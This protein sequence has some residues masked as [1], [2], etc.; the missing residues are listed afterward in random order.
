MTL[1]PI[2]ESER[3]RY[4]PL[5]PTD[6]DLARALFLDADVARYVGG[7]MQPGAITV[8]SM[9]LWT[10]RSMSG[11]IG[12]WVIIDKMVGEKLGT[13]ILLPM[14]V[15]GHDTDWDCIVGDGTPPMDIETGYILK[16]TAW[17]RG[18]AT[19]ACTRIVRF[20]FEETPLRHIVACTDP[21][22][23]TSQRVLMKSGL[24]WDGWGR[25]YGG[26]APMFKITR[27]QW[28]ADRSGP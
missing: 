14:P 12:V 15:D 2:L 25:A 21:Q 3:F 8:E 9:G 17:G 16:K 7:M 20:A 22:N 5:E 6:D 4:R 26:L 13:V 27:N 19:E 23:T 18:V 24:R 10:R 11:G 1:R 28:L